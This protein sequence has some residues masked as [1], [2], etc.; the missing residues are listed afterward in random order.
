[1]KRFGTS[2]CTAIAFALA[3]LSGGLPTRAAAEQVVGMPARPQ[4]SPAHDC[5]PGAYRSGRGDIV[6]LARDQERG[7]FYA[8]TEGPFGRTTQANSLVNCGSG[9][10]FVKRPSG[11]IETWPIIPVKHTPVQFKS[12]D[13]T[14]T[15]LLIEP[16][17]VAGKKAPLIIPVHGSN[18]RGWLDGPATEYYLLA[19]QGI[20]VFAFDKRGTGESAGKYTQDFHVL[21]KDVEAASREAKRLMAGKFGRFGLFGAS[22]GGWVGPLAARGSGAEFVA[23][24]FGG[25]FSPLEEESEEVLSNLREKGFGEDAISK[26]RQVLEATGALLESDFQSGYERLREVKALHGSEP[27]FQHIVERREAKV[28]WQGHLTGDLLFDDEA[29][30]RAQGAA[31]YNSIKVP[32]AHDSM[33]VL[34][35]LSVP[36]LWVLAGADRESVPRLTFER[37]S[38]LQGEGE[39]IEAFVFPDT[40]HNI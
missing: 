28:G 39:R 20:N 24:A 26:A 17:E 29:T 21:A 7:F 32:W 5:T 4:F 19:A 36:I 38:T 1:M 18:E 9:V 15:G 35:N 34:R 30:L 12:G 13:V 3:A 40:D 10:V 23:V 16:R 25:I 8:F 14:L 11:A 27:W 22:Q 31:K 33:A 2:T 6:A 37:L